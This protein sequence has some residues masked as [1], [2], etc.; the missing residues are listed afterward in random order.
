MPFGAHALQAQDRFGALPRGKGWKVNIS[1]RA[2]WSIMGAA[3]VLMLIAL[4]ANY[5]ATYS[6]D[7]RAALVVLMFVAYGTI[8][9]LVK[10][11]ID[12]HP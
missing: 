5:N 12:R 8:I 10:R 11:G 1:R 3:A 6:R 4:L 7:L 2:A 9:V